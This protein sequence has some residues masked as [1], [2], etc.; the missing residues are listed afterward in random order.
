[1]ITRKE[2]AI[3]IYDQIREGKLGQRGKLPS[4]RELASLFNVTRPLVRE[5][6]AILE[7]LGIIEVRDRQ[8]IFIKEKSWSEITLPL[9]FLADWPLDILPQVF[10][11]RMILEPKAAAIAAKRRTDS[12]VEKLQVTLVEMERLF[13]EDVPEKASLGEKWNSIFHALVVAAT[14]NDVLCRLHEGII[15]LYERNATSFPK[16]NVPMP[17]EKWPKEIWTEHTNIFKAIANSDSQEAAY[18][19]YQHIATTQRRIYDFTQS[20]GLRLFKPTINNGVLN[21]DKEM[22]D[23]ISNHDDKTTDSKNIKSN[24][25]VLS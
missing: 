11:A 24:F 9:S 6:L 15:R 17:F 7:A 20:L 12:D 5:A 16:E 2:L 23:L 18:W 22:N 13:K 10:E 21:V 19:A 3:C 8:G 1:M 25:K 14:R 4:E